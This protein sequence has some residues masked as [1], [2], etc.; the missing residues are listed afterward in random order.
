MGIS[1]TVVSA[2]DSTTVIV[3]DGMTD[4]EYYS[5]FE[6]LDPDKVFDPNTNTGADKVS[7]PAGPDV[8]DKVP[9]E[10]M[11]EEVVSEGNVS[12]N[13]M[14]EESDL[15]KTEESL[16]TED[17]EV[18]EEDTAIPESFEDEEGAGGET[19]EE[20]NQADE[21][22]LRDQEY[23]GAFTH[24][25]PEAAFDPDAIPG[26]EKVSEPAGPDVFGAAARQST[27]PGRW[28][29]PYGD[30]RYRYVHNDGTY[31]TNEWEW[32]DGYWYYFDANGFFKAGWIQYK[33]N[34]Y[35]CNAS[36]HMETGWVMVD[37]IYYFMA[38]DGV[39][40]YGWIFV[41]ND[42]Y[43]MHP[44]TGQMQA[45]WI[46]TNGNTYFCNASGRMVTGWFELDDGFHYCSEDIYDGKLI[47]NKGTRMVADGL[48]YLGTPYVA[49]GSDLNNG[50]DNGRFVMKIHERQGISIPATPYEQFLKCTNHF[51]PDKLQP[52]DLI[53]GNSESDNL[54]HVLFYVG[55][56][57]M[58]G[59]N[60]GKAVLHAV[61]NFGDG[62]AHGVVLSDYNSSSAHH[63]LF[64]NYGSLWR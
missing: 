29:Q 56:I 32:I 11:A 25:D 55:K 26:A 22:L 30:Y 9:D 37:G 54:N 34:T 27:I 60:H 38:N 62:N 16:E 3:D 41:D 53:W 12:R 42:W 17:L 33:G 15:D 48:K 19:E 36:G 14:S 24:L 52:G 49:G 43:Y 61:P 46:H 28:Q 23:F 35:Y 50:I 64:T 8:F 58:D 13:E 21:D 63:T 44:T 59:N 5:S 51:T 47:D 2:A 57:Q 40:C 20:T 45:G 31:T 10:S 1:A 7:K 39:R 18:I 6:H 4:E